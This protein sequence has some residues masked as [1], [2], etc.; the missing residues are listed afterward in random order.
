MTQG[1]LPGQ[2]SFSGITED[3]PQLP[4]LDPTEARTKLIAAGIYTADNAPSVEI[5][6]SLLKDIATRIEQWLGY[7]PAPT[8]Y[9]ETLRTNSDG[10]ALLRNYP[11]LDVQEI[12]VFNDA[13][14]GY[15][16]VI[17]SPNKIRGIWRQDRRIYLLSPLTSIRVTYIAGYNPLPK[18]FSQVAFQILKQVAKTGDLS[19][20]LSFLDEPV[21]DVSSISLPGGLSKSFRLGGSGGP[22][23]GSG[24]D[25]GS[26]QLDRILGGLGSYRRKIIT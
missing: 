2:F 20:D 9:I 12:A 18:G 1:F 13:T 16:P 22:K 8:G 11:V 17:I 15:E 3:I 4:L 25:T 24:K 21:R 14:P 10:V 19:G 6:D 5:L 26:T 7:S 23:G